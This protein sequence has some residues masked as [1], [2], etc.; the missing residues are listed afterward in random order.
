MLEDLRSIS[1]TRTLNTSRTP[2][3]LQVTSGGLRNNSR[4]QSIVR[5]HS[6]QTIGVLEEVLEGS[7]GPP[8]V[9]RGYWG[10]LGGFVGDRWGSLGK[11]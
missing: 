2:D 8:G 1:L 7:W 10:I 11:H 9:S 5:A 4:N 6:V 3:R